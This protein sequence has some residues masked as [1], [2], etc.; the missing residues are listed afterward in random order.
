MRALRFIGRVLVELGRG[1]GL[2]VRDIHQFF[3]RRLGARMWWIYIGIA[4][5]TALIVTGRFWNLVI[6]VLGFVLFIGLL[7]W[8]GRHLLRAMFGGG[9]RERTERRER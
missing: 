3:Y 9:R 5:V 4:F 1:L 6:Q 7:F 8:V 2:I